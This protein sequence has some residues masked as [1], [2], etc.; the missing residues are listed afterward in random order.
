[1]AYRNYE[2]SKISL[3][4]RVSL[5]WDLNP[6]CLFGYGADVLGEIKTGEA[7]VRISAEDARGLKPLPNDFGV[8][9]E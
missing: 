7:E 2:I 1:V 4:N 5:G 9:A 8:K 6:C 3:L